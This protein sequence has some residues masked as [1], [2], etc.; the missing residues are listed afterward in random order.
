MQTRDLHYTY[1]ISYLVCVIVALIAFALFD[2]PNLVDKISFALTIASLVLAVV[3]IIY[4]FM[5]ANKQDGQLAKL[6]ETHHS[7]S[8]A[9]SETRH[10]ATSLLA[11]VSQLPPRLDSIESKLGA[12]TQ[13][14]VAGLAPAL[15]P[16]TRLPQ[17]T[18]KQFQRFLASLPFG[19]MAV[20]YGFYIV[21]RKGLSLSEEDLTEWAPNSSNFAIGVL[22]ALDAMELI[23][24]KHHKGEVV[25]FGISDVVA[26]NLIPCLKNVLDVVPPE[27]AAILK[28]TMDL[29]DRKYA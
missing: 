11:H 15:S 1:G 9:A 28:T 26:K 6:L 12:L 22:V 7:I 21:Q 17:L 4:T 19:A 10:A 14:E 13:P 29:V 8:T 2:V 23:S 16:D 27:R 25:P 18:D 3:A 24:L 20:L 5:A